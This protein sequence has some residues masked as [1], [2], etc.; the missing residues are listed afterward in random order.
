MCGALTTSELELAIL[1]SFVAIP[2]SLYPIS[3]A[4]MTFNH[5]FL[6]FVFVSIRHFAAFGEGIVFAV[7]CLMNTHAEST[8]G[9][10]YYHV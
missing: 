8:F 7:H 2:L 4:D 5:H 10:I 1:S 3:H 6:V 9:T